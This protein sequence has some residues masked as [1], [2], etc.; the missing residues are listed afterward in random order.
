MACNQVLSGLPRD[1]EGSIGGVKRVLFIN[2]D[3][4]GKVTI[5]EDTGIVTAIE[6]VNGGKF[7]EFYPKKNTAS[8]APALQ[9]G[10][11]DNRSYQ[12]TLVLNFGKMTAS[13]RV[14]IQALLAN[15]LAAIVEDNNGT[16]WLAGKDVPLQATE[17]GGNTGTAMTDA[18]AYTVTMTD[19]SQTLHHTVDAKIIDALIGA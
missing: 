12:A 15:E 8:F 4:L 16:Y 10:D 3:Q 7:F 14:Q 13:K 9:V 17:G 11:G 18:N 2:H 19:M 6:P 1:C 5:E